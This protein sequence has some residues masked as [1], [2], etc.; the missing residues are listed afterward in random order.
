MPGSVPFQDAIDKLDF[1]LIRSK[2]Q[3]FTVSPYGYEHLEKL[4]PMTIFAEVHDELERVRQMSFLLDSEDSPPLENVP[5]CRRALHRA[6]LEASVLAGEDFRDILIA[7]RVSRSLRQFFRKREEKVPLLGALA[8]TLIEEKMLEFHVDRIVDEEGNVKDS[9]SKELR[10][11]RK[12]IIERTTRLRR[13]MDTILKQ[14][15]EDKITQ[16]EIITLRDGRFV[17][18]VKAEYKKS[19]PGFIHSSSAT[20]QT[21]YIEP[22]EALD[23]NNEIR[24]LQIDEQ[25]E[26]QSILTDLTKRLRSII[27]A[28]HESLKAVA[29]LDSL[30]A[31]A[32]YGRSVNATVP[33]ITK[34]F[35]LQISQGRHPVL[36]LHKKFKD[37]VPMDIEIGAPEST[38]LITGPN[39]GGKSVTMKAVGLLSLMAQCGIPIP[40]TD[41]TKIPV[42]QDIFVDIGDEQSVENDLS[43]FSSHIQ[44]LSRIVTAADGHS[45]VLIDEI[46]T[47][48]DPSEGSALGAAILEHLTERKCHLIVTTHHGMLKA[49]A[50]EHAEMQNATME[51]NLDTL[52]PTYV[53]RAGLPGSSYAF[54]ITRRHG[55]DPAIIERGRKI[56]DT[57]AGAL[58]QLL[59]DVE[60]KSQELG[61]RVRES[62]IT[63]GKYRNLVAE[64]EEKMASIKE[65]TKTMKKRAVEE[66][67]GIIDDAGSLIERTI[68]EIKESQ[69]EKDAIKAAQ[70][71]VRAKKA[72][73][74]D[75][76]QPAGSDSG[77]ELPA[78]APGQKVRMKEGNAKETGTVLHGPDGDSAVVSFGNL[79][80]RVKIDQLEPIAEKKP[81][82]KSSPMPER[83]M[84]A[85]SEVDVRGLYADEAIAEVDGF[86]YQVYG[87]GMKQA[88]IIHGKGTGALRNK[89][90]N[91]LKS[92]PIVESFGDA[93]WNEGGSGKTIVRFKAS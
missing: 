59:A 19:V 16:E 79:K 92:L 69:A 55:M 88:E 31:R 89:I 87:A 40:C 8:D 13:R 49:V 25:R 60:R 72:E 24:D 67:Q 18:P 52:E 47:G 51:F 70:E 73:L 46:G 66:A 80:M 7:L 76:A 37:V 68:R 36:L 81:E 63:L 38:I 84:P 5:D 61:N 20:G 32:R 27:P 48:T 64:Y 11:I 23:M 41:P 43:T 12:E 77:E 44:R 58:E 65:E 42:Y 28:L 26:I 10:R 9:A 2:I 90:Q 14:V 6:S 17:I 71:R 30:Y 93:P 56:L 21:V 22:T 45:L 1:E 83:T 78:I 50:H 33:E 75:Q 86:L 34:D 85:S 53:F 57:K 15:A 74:R 54:E 62:E 35:H 82:K 3:S 4:E 39:A 29:V 91:W